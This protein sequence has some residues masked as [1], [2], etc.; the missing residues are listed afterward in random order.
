MNVSPLMQ[1]LRD[2]LDSFDVPWVDVS[3]NLGNVADLGVFVFERT[4][5]GEIAGV[6]YHAS[7]VYIY[8]I[9]D[10]MGFSKG[11][12]NKLEFWCRYYYPDP[13]AMTVDEIIM[14]L[15]CCVS[16]SIRSTIQ[17]LGNS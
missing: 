4:K 6:D 13:L 12:P 9:N 14:A 5:I 17:Q 7:V 11:F 3:E 2:R 8:N 16:Q 15:G 1:E 10:D